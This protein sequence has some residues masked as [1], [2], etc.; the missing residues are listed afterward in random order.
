[1]SQYFAKGRGRAYLAAV[2]LLAGC[3]PSSHLLGTGP[4]SG[5]V[6]EWQT[7]RHSVEQ[8][9]SDPVTLHGTMIEKCPTAACWFRLQDKSGVV[10]VDVKGAYFTVAEVPTGTEVT[11]HGKLHKEGDEWVLAGTGL[12]Y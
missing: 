3:A 4:V 9:K 7:A 1:M 5:P 12:T 8:G 10:K 11:V 2:L 6:V